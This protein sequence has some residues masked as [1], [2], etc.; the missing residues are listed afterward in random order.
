MFM[1][2]GFDVRGLESQG[3]WLCVWKG[4]RY[5]PTLHVEA[6]RAERLRMPEWA[7]QAA[8]EA[9]TGSV[10]IVAYRQNRRAWRVDLSLADLLRLIG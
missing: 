4:H 6:K 9:P 10:P 5:M 2:A 3:D 8:S 7:A 1:A